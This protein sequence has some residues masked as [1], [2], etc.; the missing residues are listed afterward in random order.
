MTVLAKR[1]A[2]WVAAILVILVG[3][4]LSV[5]GVPGPGFF[6][7]A[8]GLFLLLPESRWLRKKYVSFKRRHPKVFAPIERHR[9]RARLR[10][11][12][13]LE[14]LE[15]LDRGALAAHEAE[16]AARR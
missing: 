5:P 16:G 6:V 11:L 14:G 1:L 2:R 12:V 4:F 3:L 10:R 15:R 9:R 7:I 13:R 8:F